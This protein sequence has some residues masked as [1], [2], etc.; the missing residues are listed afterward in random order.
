M[1]ESSRISQQT[2][3][4]AGD[5]IGL[6]ESSDWDL[7][8]VLDPRGRVLQASAPSSNPDNP[9]TALLGALANGSIYDENVWSLRPDMRTALC[10]SLAAGRPLVR[11]PATLLLAEPDHAFWVLLDGNPLPETGLGHYA[12]RVSA[13][14]RFSGQRSEPSQTQAELD[15]YHTLGTHWFWQFDTSE[16][17]NRIVGAA[18]MAKGIPS[19]LLGRTLADLESDACYSAHWS[20]L[21]HY[22]HRRQQFHGFPFEIHIGDDWIHYEVS[23]EPIIVGGQ[24]QGFRGLAHDVTQRVEA[25]RNLERLARFDALTGALTRAY[26]E[27]EVETFIAPLEGTSIHG[28]LMLI[29]VI[30]MRKL[31]AR[32]GHAV[33]N[34]YLKALAAL[35]REQF[36]I[37]KFI[38][39]RGG[40]QLAVFIW[41][42]DESFVQEQMGSIAT[43]LLE[44][45]PSSPSSPGPARLRIGASQ[46]P[47]QGQDLAELTTAA[48]SAMHHLKTTGMPGLQVFDQ[49]IAL[50]QDIQHSFETDVHRL[51]EQRLF[52]L[53]FQPIADARTGQWSQVEALLRWHGQGHA[54]VDTQR[55]V[56]LAEKTRAIVAI[57]QWVQE[58]ALRVL[59]DLGDQQTDP[60]RLS[61]N[62]S[63]IEL[64]QEDF[65]TKLLNKLAAFQVAPNRITL[66]ITETV[67]L[68]SGP[69]T[70]SNIARLRQSGVRFALDDFGTGYSGYG[71]LRQFPYD[72]LKLDRS[73]VQGIHLDPRSLSLVTSIVGLAKELQFGVIA[74]G[75]ELAD[76]LAAIQS[77]GCPL[78]QGFLISR[79]V[80]R[81]VLKQLYSAQR[82][83][84]GLDSVPDCLNSDVI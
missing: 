26:F 34:Q 45:R 47:S 1:N 19:V 46:W 56:L 2:Q 12:L 59:V 36:G 11:I 18:T 8:L 53:E 14:H 33:G 66:E 52:S 6:G 69:N 71:L 29:D 10:E 58:E 3:P 38:G 70:A 73:L 28:A 60:I 48:E 44:L 67:L 62:T 25:F 37:N 27:A 40:D 30:G 78:V 80:T 32:F 50:Q 75:V 15:V 72:E 9:L 31:N 23:G 17:F 64:V 22:V 83:L 57:G 41:H 79:P 42:E 16:R 65:A 63:A 61:I 24:Y 68:E 81:P 76:E 35:L 4:T 21:R 49:N 74:E 5:G 20:I 84:Q 39:R 7:Q 77:S 82:I 55:V 13:L 54:E 51:I 43:A